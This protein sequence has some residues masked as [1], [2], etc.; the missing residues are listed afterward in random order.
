MAQ[1]V[2]D[3]DIVDGSDSHASLIAFA[4]LWQAKRRGDLLPGRKDFDVFE[5]RE[6]LGSVL[7]MDVLDGGA[8]FRYRL[9]GETL[10]QAN[11]RDLTGKR[12]SEYDFGGRTAHVLNTFQRP[13]ETNAPVFRRGRMVWNAETNY[14]S[15]ESV[16][17]PLAA[18]GETV[19][20]TIGIQRYFS[21]SLD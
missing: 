2:P 9:V 17:C 18:D 6:W 1:D 3:A 4:D 5:L 10:V 19:D 15:Y 21:A 11:R 16:H 7:M 12:V 8:D 20:M 13:I 14:R